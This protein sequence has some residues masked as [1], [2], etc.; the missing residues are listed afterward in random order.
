MLPKHHVLIG[1][2]LSILITYSF[3]LGFVAGI[4]IFLSSFLIDVDHYLYYVC[5]KNDL[6]LKK[7]YKWFVKRR[8]QFLKLSPKQREN[9]KVPIM[10]FHGIEYWI[11]LLLLSF[12]HPF[13]IW[14][15]VGIIIHFILDIAEIIEYKTNPI[16]KISQIGLYIRNKNKKE[17][18]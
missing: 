8:K 1:L 4:T 2:V 3:N 9:Y 14:V 5:T 16:I 7:A 10:L 12:I 15:F 11:L 18:H 13:F 6:S 17:L